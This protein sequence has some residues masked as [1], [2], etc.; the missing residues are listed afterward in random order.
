[1]TITEALTLCR[2]GGHKGRPVCW[3]TVNAGCW[4]EAVPWPS[5]KDKVIFVEKGR[6]EEMPHAL[7]LQFPAELLGEWE[8]YDE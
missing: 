7:R 1:M 8:V 3:R 2:D 5:G 6:L 4:V